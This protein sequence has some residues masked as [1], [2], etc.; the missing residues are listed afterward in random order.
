VFDNDFNA[1]I[2]FD[3]GTSG[4]GSTF[5]ELPAVSE[6]SPPGALQVIPNQTGGCLFYQDQQWQVDGGIERVGSNTVS[7]LSVRN[8][9]VSFSAINGWVT[10]ASQTI[11][12]NSNATITVTATY[13]AEGSLQVTINPAAAVGAGAQWSVN[14]GA[15][16][17][18]GATVPDLVPTNLTVSFTAIPGWITPSNQTVLI[19]SGQTTNLRVT[20]VD[21][22]KPT[23]TILSPKPAERV[24][25]SVFIVTGTA[26]DNVGVAGVWCQLNHGGWTAAATTNNWT[27]W[28]ATL[29]AIPGTHTL[30]AYAQDING[31]GF[32]YVADTGNNLIRQITPDGLVTTLPGATKAGYADGLEAAAR[33][34]LPMGIATEASG[35]NLSLTNP[36]TFDCVPASTLQVQMVGPGTITPDYSN[37]LLTL[38]DHYSVTAAPKHGSGFAF[39]N[40]TLS[41]PLLPAVTTNPATLQFTM[42]SN[43][44]LTTTFVDTRKPTDRI[45]ALVKDERVSNAVF[46]VTGVAGD[47]VGVA[48][49]WYQLNNSGW[50]LAT[51]TDNWTNWSATLSLAAGSNILRTCAVD[52]AGRSTMCVADTGNNVIREIS[53]DGVVTTLAGN[54]DTANGQFADGPAYAALFN[55]PAGVAVDR[56]GK[57]FVADTRN[58]LIR[59]ITQEGLVT[60]LAGDTGDLTNGNTYR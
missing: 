32:L 24:S 43:L 50:T 56:A 29:P 6:N 22:L 10:P 5:A 30:Q 3:P 16:Q 55:Q 44:T 18:N 36:V 46:T 4:W 42:A 9:T 52:T 57:V 11:W 33:F 28:W 40:W 7:G 38:G 27:N 47:N 37:A 54:T 2:Y 23:L 49:V 20:Y 58:N 12:V 21:A 41:N 53:P 26:G 13:V 45:T 25:N 34:N 1:T 19:S 59:Q 48:E 35:G 39:T 60:T 14:G 8:H 17:T 51:T 15:C 31:D